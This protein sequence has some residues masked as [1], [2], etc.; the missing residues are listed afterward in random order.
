MRPDHT[1]VVQ[2]SH[3]RLDFYRQF[4][5][6]FFQA[7]RFVL[8]RLQLTF[9]LGKSSAELAPEQTSRPFEKKAA[10]ITIEYRPLGF[11]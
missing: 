8:G 4:R 5:L 3:N 6:F 9:Q 10:F 2:I 11:S 7:S 1:H